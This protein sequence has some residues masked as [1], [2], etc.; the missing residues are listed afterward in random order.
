MI[1]NVLCVYCKTINVDLSPF[2]QIPLKFTYLL[3]MV[4]CG[5]NVVFLKNTLITRLVPIIF[6]ILISSNTTIQ[7][8]IMYCCWRRIVPRDDYHMCSWR[9]QQLFIVLFTEGEEMPNFRSIRSES[10]IQFEISFYKSHS[11]TLFCPRKISIHHTNSF[12]RNSSKL[13]RNILCF[14]NY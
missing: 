7:G 1:K 13:S 6:Q 3:F 9:C 4:D 14:S 5:L 12:F 8:T 11:K 10:N 2:A